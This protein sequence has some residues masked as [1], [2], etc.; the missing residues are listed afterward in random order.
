[1]VVA[2]L[3]IIMISYLAYINP[4]CNPQSA[5]HFSKQKRTMADIKSIAAAIEHYKSDYGYYP[6]NLEVLEPN[7]IRELPA[8]DGWRNPF[9][10]VTSNSQQD[11]S[12]GSG[13]RDG[14]SAN[15]SFGLSPTTTRDFD[16]DIV[17]F[18]GQFTIYPEGVQT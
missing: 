5:I 1:V 8:S 6:P 18:D 7:Y 10:Y 4:S 11:Y 2:V 9:C 14:S 13:G 3:G 16:S 17:F 15:G 12:I